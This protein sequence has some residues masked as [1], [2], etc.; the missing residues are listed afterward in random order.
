MISAL[1]ASSSDRCETLR[2]NSSGSR[3]HCSLQCEVCVSYGCLSNSAM[4]ITGDIPSSVIVEDFA[5]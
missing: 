4:W 1:R 5:G 2:G 3:E